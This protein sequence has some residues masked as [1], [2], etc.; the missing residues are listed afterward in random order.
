MIGQV[1]LSIA[2]WAATV[3]G[4]FVLVPVFSGPF[5]IASAFLC[6]V[7]TGAGVLLQSWRTPRLLVPLIQLLVLVETMALAFYSDTLKYV[8]VPWKETALAF[9]QNMV[10]ALEGINKYSAPLPPETYFT[11]FAAGVIALTGLLIH[12]IAVQ[13]RQASWSGL[14]LLMMYTVPAATVHGGLSAVWFIP[15]AIGYIVLLSAEGRARLSRWG[16]RIGGVTT[17]DA[18]DQ[19]EASA[20]G[21]AGRRIGLTV[22]A[23]AALLPALLP[24]LPEG[25][26]GNGVA[27][28]A[29]GT[30]PGGAVSLG[31]NPMLDMGK[32]LR[33]GENSVALTYT[34]DPTY[35]RLTV[36]DQFD[37]NVWTP[38]PRTGYTNVDG[39]FQPPPG[40]QLPLD[41][42][43]LKR[44]EMRVTKLLRSPWVP[45]PYPPHTLS[46]NNGK[47]RYDTSAMDISSKNSRSVAG[48]R[49][50]VTSY[51]IDPTE[52]QL[53][54][55]LET[56]APDGYTLNV[57]RAMPPSIRE[58]AQN[59]TISAKGNH[60]LEAAA[61][62]KY[63]RDGEFRYDT[64]NDSRSGMD[65]IES[66]LFDSKRG[67][68][69]Q[70]ATAMALMA[71]TL[72]IPARVG[73]GFLPGQ[74][75]GNKHVVRMHDMHAWPELYFEGIGW[76]RFEPTPAQQTGRAPDWTQP[77]NTNPT[78]NPSTGP[79]NDP[80]ASA[81]GNPNDP[82]NRDPEANLPKEPDA[83]GGS[84]AAPVGWW[85]GNGPRW[86]G[87]AL[88]V[89]VLSLVPW[90]VRTLVRRR[91]FSR[92]PSQASVEGLW[93]EIRDTA[94]DI[95][96][97]WSDAATPRQSGSWLVGKLPEDV[98]PQAIRL[99]RAVEFGRY[100]GVEPRE[101]DLR[102]QA[103]SVRTALFRSASVGQRWRARLLPR[104]W[105]WYLSRGSSEASDLLDQFDLGLARLRSM[106]IPR[107]R[108]T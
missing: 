63:L 51:E 19:I 86:G 45:V 69:E 65:A 11:V 5:L 3:L 90:L 12:V 37:G 100:A 106:F 36:L 84:G 98:R 61:L 27:G 15:P 23:V 7:V 83:N 25:V 89:I 102:D 93:A 68:C 80:T 55:A 22:I 35:L 10:D 16:R 44:H 43:L 62:Q 9:N 97:D 101:V 82:D 77:T 20:A 46:I 41:S 8:V 108:S 14:L 48:V 2:A 96:L 47:W 81:S 107:R 103:R 56:G 58:L 30:G 75:D 71:R 52:D 38:A 64:S 50:K 39:D 99:A 72:G 42:L 74:A 6:A 13:F 17:L 59:I 105:R 31:V 40:L 78:D 60:Y 4:A 54:G 33:Q 1:R 94:R 76:V 24:S 88:A 79:T 85:N 91:R 53:R 95:G 92:S 67:Y 34:G 32:N 70:F 29:G 18:N 28:G 49:Y 87:G 26:F 104:S 57:P 21:Q 73:I 66:F